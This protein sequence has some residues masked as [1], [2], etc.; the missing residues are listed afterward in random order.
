MLFKPENYP[1][2]SANNHRDII[3]EPDDRYNCIAWAAGIDDEWWEPAIGKIWH[4]NAPGAD[5][6]IEHDTPEDL[7][8]PVV[9]TNR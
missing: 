1:N 3:S 9:R 6:R 4:G 2:L 7:V 8:G 5:E